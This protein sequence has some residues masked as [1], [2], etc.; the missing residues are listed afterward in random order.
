MIGQVIGNYRIV[1]ELGR[2]GMGMVYRAEHT[3]L[4]RPAALKM[5]Q[6]QMSTDA[7]IVQRFFNEARAASSIDHPGI[8][9]VYDFGTHTDGRAYIVMALLKGESLA[10]R[11]ER[12]PMPA[13]EGATVMVQVAS[14]LAA[15]HARGIVHRD[16]KPDNIF[17]VPNEMMPNGI[18]VKLLD[19]G[20]AKLAD[21]Q[22]A[23]F[24]TQTGALIG[25]PAYMSPEQ[26]MGR[27]DLDHRT[28]L[29]SFGCILFH[30]LCGRPPF[31]GE[32][33][34]GMMIAAHIRDAPPD[35]RS[36]NPNI[37][38]RLAAIMLRLLEKEPAAR[39]QSAAELKQA[40]VDAGA[41]GSMS[42][43]PEPISYA[44]TLAAV[45][46]TTTRGG[47]AGQMMPAPAKRSTAPIWIG[48]GLVAVAVAGVV[49]FFV[50]RSGETHEQ[51]VSRTEGSTAPATAPPPAAPTTTPPPPPKP[52]VTK[53]AEPPEPPVV[54][55]PAPAKPDAKVSVR[56][57]APRYAPK[58]PIEVTFGSPISSKQKSQAWVTIVEAGKPPNAY[59]AY[60]YLK[61]GVRSVKLKAP[62]KE[63]AYE[64]RLHTDFPTKRTNL[65]AAVPFEVKSAAAA[66]SGATAG[67]A[68]GS[69]SAAGSAAGSGA[70]AQAAVTPRDKW[71][72][73]LATTTLK[74]K[75]PAKVTFPA[76][77]HAAK[78]EQFWITVTA[79]GEPDDTWGKY[80]YVPDGAKHMTLQMP[81]TPGEYEV[82]LHAN[83]PAKTTNL[84]YR[85]KLKVESGP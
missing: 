56:V 69:G 17:L 41:Q 77:M 54:S 62:E 60:D 52:A 30:M 14:A 73:T 51:T 12:G 18:Q 84:V 72:F 44:Q 82:R 29:Y 85:A 33:G 32:Q 55:K 40:L 4:G 66:G 58:A 71:R 23:G 67:S 63:G 1:S 19:F 78:S 36:I 81:P 46:S 42:R 27:S 50:A 9:E 3:Q 49:V 48:L 7:S 5:L 74:P 24:K 65:V 26:C 61:D 8:V 70:L 11:L 53:P 15:A 6:P 2:G 83:Y 21:D 22:G 16:L 59:N 57:D 37:P 64:V 47:S 31:L 43:P 76:A 75:E 38:G 68:Q 28:D 34:T 39:Y 13:I 45:P 80:E 35:P 25:T 79:A 10:T 20:I